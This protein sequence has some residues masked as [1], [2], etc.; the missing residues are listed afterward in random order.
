LGEF[1]IFEDGFMQVFI[2]YAKEDF[3]KSDRLYRYLK[4]KDINVWMDEYS[5]KGGED[6]NE[7]IK[8]KY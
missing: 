3:N 4:A 1:L 2:S 5:L 6:W 8:K 7:T